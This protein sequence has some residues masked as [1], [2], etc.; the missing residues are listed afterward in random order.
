MLVKTFWQSIKLRQCDIHYIKLLATQCYKHML[1]CFYYSGLRSVSLH[2][3]P[4]LPL[5]LSVYVSLPLPISAC[6]CLFMLLFSVSGETPHRVPRSLSYRN[7]VFFFSLSPNF[8][9]SCECV[10]ANAFLLTLQISR[11]WVIRVSG[12]NLKYD[13]KQNG[14]KVVASLLKLEV[15]LVE[16]EEVAADTTSSLSQ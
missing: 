13:D 11:L 6:C 9:A 2:P 15:L 5:L 7:S 1:G 4:L 14:R 3:P 10:W 16:E 8:T 12:R